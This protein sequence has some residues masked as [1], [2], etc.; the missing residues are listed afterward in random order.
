MDFNVNVKITLEETPALIECFSTFIDCLHKVATT[1]VVAAV[2]APVVELDC[3][4]LKPETVAFIQAQAEP[5]ADIAKEDMYF[6]HSESDA[7]W[8]VK[9]GEKL[10]SDIDTELS[11]R[12]SKEAYEAGIAKQTAVQ[13]E[14][15]PVQA[16]HKYT[17][18]EIQSACMPLMDEGKLDDLAE[19]LKSFGAST[20]FEVAE[21]Q[22]DALVVALIGL[23]AK[24]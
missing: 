19:V 15:E 14:Q 17:I 1:P 2:P 24:L 9:K 8:M 13:A 6:Y 5:V 22:Y 12:I 3:P 11:V 20:L 23:G 10:S 4:P 16:K 18:A 21:E 7:Y